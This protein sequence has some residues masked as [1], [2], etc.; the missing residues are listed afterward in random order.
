MFGKG[1]CGPRNRPRSRPPLLGGRAAAQG[2][3]GQQLKGAAHARPNT[4]RS[5]RSQ[6]PLTPPRRRPGQGPGSA[7]LP[8]VAPLRGLRRV[9]HR[10]PA[11]P[12]AL[13][14]SQARPLLELLTVGGHEAE[15]R[16]T[17]GD[18]C[19]SKQELLIC[20]LENPSLPGAGQ[21]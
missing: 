16:V 14:V 21:A 4:T 1:G 12:R 2:A 17:E 20:S 5:T 9:P 3:A 19:P 18:L 6:R 7:L 11:P 13:I 15:E 10:R 8:I